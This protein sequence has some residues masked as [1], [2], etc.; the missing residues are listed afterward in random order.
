[1]ICLNSTDTLEGGA[2]VTNVVDFTVHGLVAGVFTNLAQGQLSD[3]NPSVLYTAG[4]AISIVSVTFVNTHSAAVTVDLYLDPANAGTPRRLIPKTL[5]LGIGYSMHWDGARCT[6][7]DASG[8]LLK[9]YA[10]HSD[11]H[12]AGGA[13]PL[14]AA[15]G[16]IGGTTPAA[17]AFTTIAASGNITPDLLTA[18]K[19]VFTDA[20][21]NLVSTGTLAVDQGGTGKTTLTDGGVLV[22]AG[23]GVVEILSVGTNGQVLVGSTGANPVFATITDG[24]GIDTTLG[25]GT[26]TIAAETASDTNPGVVELAIDS[27]AVAGTDT[28]RAI[29]SANLKAKLGSQTDGGIL[30]GA[31]TTAA[32]EAVAVGLTTQILVGGGAG[33]N[34]AWGTDIPT[35]V[36]VGGAYITRVGGTDVIVA[37]GGTGVSTLA[38]GGLVIGNAANAVEVV[39][40]GLTTE[41]LVGGGALTN[42][43]WTTATG[44]GA[45]VR[46]TSPTL[47]TP[48]LG[49]PTSGDLQNCTAT[50]ETTKGVVEL[51]T[52]AEAIAGTDTT[53]ALTAQGNA[54][55]EA[56][57]KN[58]LAVAQGIHLT[59]GA[60]ASIAVADN[61]N[62]DFGTGNFTLRWK[63]SLPDWTPSAT[64]Y[65]FDKQ[66]SPPNGYL[67]HIK[68]TGKIAVY[69]DL[70]AFGGAI[71]EYISTFT[72]AFVDGTQHELV[73]VITRENASTAGSIVFYADGVQIGNS[74]PITAAATLSVNSTVALYVLG[75]GTVR[76]ESIVQ[77]ATL[78]NRA[79]TAA[80][81][82][83][84]Y[85]NG[86]AF[87]DKWGSQTSLV[88]GDDSTFASDTGFW[89]KQAGV[90]IADGVCHFINVTSAGSGLYRNVAELELGKRYFITF[91]ISNR[92]EGGVRFDSGGVGGTSGETRTADG[93]YTQEVIGGS[94]GKYYFTP[95]GETSLDI[96][97]VTFFQIGATLDL[98]PE[99]I[100]PSPGQWLDS[101]SNKLHAMQPATGSSLIRK[102]DTFEVRWTNTWAGTHEA[103]YIGGVNQA[104]LPTGCYITSI[105]GVVAG[106]T[107]EDIIIGDGSDTDHWVAITTG[108]A[109]GTTAFTIAS[110]ISD[111]TNYKLVVDP[112]ANFTG[113]I[114]WTIRGIILQ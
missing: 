63:G 26:L 2:S 84:L 45:P 28:S 75:N 106:S 5:S 105:I 1:M 24:E 99:G 88:T 41:I 110:P 90:T 23:T 95:I 32:V 111:G 60:T 51:A 27:E 13:D 40:A 38:D 94:S 17:G 67:M 89:S 107:I 9:G 74:V 61:A 39:A 65:L 54:A 10:S 70:R 102:K 53:R 101:S 108:L 18:S 77:A 55:S 104:V 79:L 34:P 3:T 36:T 82:L 85:R 113:S 11:E 69:L 91:T 78:Y 87:S 76:Y 15:P 50:T 98:E 47:A 93:T 44:T 57:I 29:T 71:T 37:D 109:A 86:V 16:A 114:A 43:V 62:I 42:P 59:S 112:D 30:V 80:Q 6:V 49:T 58:P 31:G 92:T 72:P 14:L 52:V 20:S 7:M 25:A 12:K 100:Q 83:D 103:Q 33:T 81:V 46:A 35:A 97:N 96:D 19:P 8:R 21:K 48:L 68:T 73:S 66:Q 64:K 4:A 22:G 56:I